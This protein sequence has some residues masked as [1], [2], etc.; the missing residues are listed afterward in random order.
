[1]RMCQKNARNVLSKIQE[2]PSQESQ[3]PHSD[4]RK[5]RFELCL[6]LNQDIISFFDSTVGFV[7][8]ILI[9]TSGAPGQTVKPGH[10][11]YPELTKD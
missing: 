1:M 4:T 9:L 5:T 3:P 2:M 10:P 11:T 7:L 6:K 8:F